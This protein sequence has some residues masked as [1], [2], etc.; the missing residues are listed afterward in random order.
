MR[1]KLDLADPFACR[2]FATGRLPFSLVVAPGGLIP[3]PGRCGEGTGPEIAITF[4]PE[5]APEIRQLSSTE[6]HAA[7]ANQAAQTAA[8]CL[9][10]L[11]AHVRKTDPVEVAR[12]LR[13]SLSAETWSSNAIGKHCGCGHKHLSRA[14]TSGIFCSGTDT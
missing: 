3:D 7:A 2:L 4:R 8:R 1:P 9:L 10:H 12:L 6:L 11:I 5:N 14:K 13:E